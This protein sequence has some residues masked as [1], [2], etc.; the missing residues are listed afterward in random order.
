MLVKSYLRAVK[1]SQKNNNLLSLA[2]AQTARSI[3]ARVSSVWFNKHVKSVDI[4]DQ[5]LK[6]Y[7][8]DA[9]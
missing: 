2:N 5:S 3:M 6:Q 8:S 7:I 1:N 4:S 9:I